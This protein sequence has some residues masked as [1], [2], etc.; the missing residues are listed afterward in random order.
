MLLVQVTVLLINIRH[1]EIVDF[2]Q[3]LQLVLP[4]PL[5]IITFDH[6]TLFRSITTILPFDTVILF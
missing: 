3:R 4:V 1:I 5:F 2:I 6:S